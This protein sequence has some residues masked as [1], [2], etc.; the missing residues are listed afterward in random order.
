VPRR[1][2]HLDPRRALS[3]LSIALAFGIAAYAAVATRIPPV[4]ATVV[5]WDVA[6]LALLGLSWAIIGTADAHAT[7][8]RAGSEDPGRT[9]VYVIVL[10]SSAVS[11]LAATALVRSARVLPSDERIAVV[12]LCL[13]SVALAWTITHT[14]FIFRYA[15]LYYREDAE[16]VGG[17]TLPGDHLPTYFD[18]AYFAFTIGMCFQV[19]D[20]CVTSRQIRR[21][22]LLHAVMSFAY[23]SAILAFVLNLV[24]G[25]AT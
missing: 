7:R 6:G 13:G 19:S 4:A 1:L 24:F 23:N 21:A 12:G 10:L 5:A 16:G 8:N 9:L 15:H 22:V 20:V 2:Q 11:V 3:R 18:F 17:V 14:A 25:I